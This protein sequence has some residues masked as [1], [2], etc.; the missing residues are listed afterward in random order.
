VDDKEDV[1]AKSQAIRKMLK[2]KNQLPKNLHK[3]IL[4]TAIEDLGMESEVNT[5]RIFSDPTYLTTLSETYEPRRML[6]GQP[7]LEDSDI[8]FRRYFIGTFLK[9]FPPVVSD[10]AKLQALKTF[11]KGERICHLFN[12]ENYKTVLKLDDF[13]PRFMN[14]I[15]ELRDDISSMIG[16]QPDLARM[17]D[18]A[19]HGPGV[20]FGDSYGKGKST[21]FYK[22]RSYPYLVTSDALYYAVEMIRSDA[23]FTRAL[24][25]R[26][27]YSVE[28]ITS[29]FIDEEKIIMHFIQINEYNRITTVPKSAKTDRTIAIENVL[30]VML[31][32]GIEKQIRR[33]LKTGWKIDL[34]TQVQNQNLARI[35]SQSNKLATVD[36][37]M[38]SD[39]VA[40]KAC[41]LLLPEA[42]YDLL[43]ALRSPFGRHEGKKYKFSGK[44]EK[45]SAMG[46]GFTFALE[47]LIF[48]AL[49]RAAIRR[50][51][52]D[53]ILA[54]FGDDVVLPT[55][56]YEYYVDLL[57]LF[58]F[59]INADKSFSDGPFRESC[60][61]DYLYG[62]NIRPIFLKRKLRNLE[63]LCYIHNS[64]YQLEEKLPWAWGVKFTKTRKLINKYFPR[65]F[66]KFFKGPPSDS[67]DTYIFS[68][69]CSFRNRYGEKAHHF[70]QRVAL[71]YN[72]DCR[73]SDF[74]FRM[75]MWQTK[76]PL[77]KWNK[78]DVITVGQNAFEITRRDRTALR[79]GTRRFPV[80]GDTQSSKHKWIDL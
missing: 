55:T 4:A 50:T 38:A 47:S 17:Y 73:A 66:K 57:E 75:L 27:H 13:H 74:Y 80:R 53:D 34:D 36:K 1:M 6:D 39:T 5:G 31:Q 51:G 11:I 22:W 59:C 18:D 79:A 24:I 25:D 12:T 30:N 56:A 2:N 33:A 21:S 26:Y 63:D 58:G 68:D 62:I 77:Q 10:T 65:L 54:V 67:L 37:K 52:S 45:M 23:R 71:R 60:G 8:F 29:P 78:K 46:N 9:K 42:W 61:E 28:V 35:G 16:E 70:L 3:Q 44:Y 7:V 40:I 20:S 72:R 32:L 43:M 76:T 41:E 19:R 15:Q 49:A 48:A 69:K 64:L 14:I